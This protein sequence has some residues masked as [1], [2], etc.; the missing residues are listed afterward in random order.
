VNKIDWGNK[1]CGFIDLQNINSASIDVVKRYLSICTFSK[2]ICASNQHINHRSGHSEVPFNNLLPINL[3]ENARQR[4]DYGPFFMVS[5]L[6]PLSSL[7]YYSTVC[8]CLN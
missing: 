2:Q 8:L 3:A 5:W 7:V 4:C 1:F 6:Q